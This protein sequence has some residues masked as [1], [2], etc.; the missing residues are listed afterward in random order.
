ML[1]EIPRI[2]SYG[3]F[4]T[5]VSTF[6]L[7]KEASYD[8]MLEVVRK[9]I[10]SKHELMKDSESTY[11]ESMG[12]N[13]LD[14]I[15]LKHFK[16]SVQQCVDFYSEEYNLKRSIIKNSWMN[17]VGKGGS[18]RAHRHEGSVVSGAFYPIADEGS[19]P[20]IFK[21]PISMYRMSE[22][23]IG[24][25]LYNAYNQEVPC[26]QGQL[27]LFPSWLEHYT[28]DNKTDNRITVS[29]NTFYQ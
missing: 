3:L 15:A 20:L 24:E 6:D 29:F 27:I 1:T 2:A 4:P 26:V 13:W 12:N 9:T 23:L 14:H 28:E 16:E 22:V 21:S 8:Q 18:V 7:S 19:C 25:N 5:L 10:T 11:D 17:R